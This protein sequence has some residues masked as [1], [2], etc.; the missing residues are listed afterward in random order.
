MMCLLAA[1]I[2]IT[3]IDED[4]ATCLSVCLSATSK[5]LPC[6]GLFALS[7]DC[8]LWMMYPYNH[9]CFR[10]LDGRLNCATRSAVHAIHT[11]VH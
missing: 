4:D 1:S 2:H 6:C 9:I 5:V 11:G 3:L 10:C 7:G 8:S